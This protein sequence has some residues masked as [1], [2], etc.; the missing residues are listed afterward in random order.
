MASE[1]PLSSYGRMQG[2]VDITNMKKRSPTDDPMMYNVKKA[3]SV[4][5]R[6][7]Q[8]D[9]KNKDTTSVVSS[10]GYVQCIWYIL[11]VFCMFLYYSHSY[12]DY[13]V[14]QRVMLHSYAEIV[15]L[16]GRWWNEY[17][18]DKLALPDYV[19]HLTFIYAIYL[20][21]TSSYR[22]Y[23]YLLCHMQILHIPCLIWYL[24]CRN[25]CLSSSKVIQNACAVI[26]APVWLYCV[27]YRLTIMGVAAVVSYL[28][29][30]IYYVPLVLGFN[31]LILFAIDLYW[32]SHFFDTLKPQSSITWL[33]GLLLGVYCSYY[34]SNIK[35]I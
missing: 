5:E 1:Q 8:E 23:A 17:K 7:T 30:D 13:D 22:S 32:S 11:S 19:H 34:A 6:A 26:F 16:F 29:S 35:N 15:I 2:K 25:N 33:I 21:Q 4:K 14:N 20:G 31:T 10:Y 9:K 18:Y 24:G 12:M 27:F 28:N 3:L